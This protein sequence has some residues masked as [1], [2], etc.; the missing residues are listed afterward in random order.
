MSSRLSPRSRLIGVAAIL[1]GVFAPTLGSSWT[2]LELQAGVT[3]Q[4]IVYA[5]PGNQGY[6]E[7]A[8]LPTDTPVTPL[9]AYGD[10]VKI[11]WQDKSCAKNEGFTLATSVA[12][13]P[14]NLAQLTQ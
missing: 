4:G 12:N 6:P 8:A 10:F 13:L 2:T 3:A 1:A 7:I 5:G 9:A 11:Q 14:R